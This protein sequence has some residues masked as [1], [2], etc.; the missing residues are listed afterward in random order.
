MGRG[1]TEYEG[2]TIRLLWPHGPSPIYMAAEGPK[3]LRLAGRIADGV[4]VGTGLTHEAI[5]GSLRYLE[6]GLS[7]SN[8]TL[9]D[10]DVWWMAKWNIAESRAA[11]VHEIRM[12]LAASCN[13]AFR[14]ALEG[15]FVPV[16][17]H[18]PIRQLQAEYAF[19]EHEKHGATLLNAELP[20]RLG[21]TEYLAQ[22]FAIVGTVRDFI[23]R[24]EELADLGIRQIRL[25]A[26]GEDRPRLL[27]RVADEVMPNFGR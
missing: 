4:I 21:L 23:E 25:S 9:E 15:K 19:K 17:Y 18:D 5:E 27:R 16:E 3:S 20:D 22:R 10:I 2:R 6:E 14:F 13:H 7:E 1:E 11:A 24:C 8:R 26:T 12:G